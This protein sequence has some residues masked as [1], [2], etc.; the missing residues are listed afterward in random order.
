MTGP[1]QSAANRSVVASGNSGEPFTYTT[2]I[3]PKV[4]PHDSWHKL[5][6]DNAYRKEWDSFAR[7]LGLNPRNRNNFPAIKSAMQGYF[8][9]VM[10]AASRN[11]APSESARADAIREVR[12]QLFA[13]KTTEK[14]QG[15]TAPRGGLTLAGKAGIAALANDPSLSQTSWGQLFQASVG[16]VRTQTS[17]TMGFAEGVF[18][19]GKDLVVGLATV[20]GKSAQYIAD[21]TVGGIVDPIRSLL[22]S[23]AQEWMRSS[24]IIPSSDRGAATTDKMIDTVVNAGSYIANSSPEKVG[25]DINAFVSKNWDKLEASHAEA[26]AK[27]PEVEAR[28]WGQVTGRAAFEVAAV[29]VP[30]TKVA[31][32]AKLDKAADVAR[33]A[34]ALNDADKFDDAGRMAGKAPLVGEALKAEAIATV[35]RSVAVAKAVRAMPPAAA[36]EFLLSVDNFAVRENILRTLV[37]DP[38]LLDVTTPAN[39]ATFYSGR[40]ELETGE[41]LK[42]R[43]WAE[44]LSARTTLEKTSGG[45]WLDQVKT[46]DD[47]LSRPVADEV[48]TTLSRRYAENVSGDVVVVKGDMRPDA[49]LHAELKILEAAQQSG[50]ITSLKTIDLQTVVE[51][52]T[53]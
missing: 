49:V 25:A 21:N 53:K 13:P 41:F 6:L 2:K 46:Y 52:L 37:S 36:R 33:G 29:V 19:G 17:F 8:D 14:L 12:T 43:D 42:A 31:Q 39:K 23:G 38:K 24:E 32:L 51:K 22:P 9:R 7:D 20:V 5:P 48:W 50:R 18:N 26:A 30:A 15:L 11:V 4:P 1:I 34:D 45:R 3:S 28:W 47:V 27:G 35:G 40:V 16:N 10:K 44:G